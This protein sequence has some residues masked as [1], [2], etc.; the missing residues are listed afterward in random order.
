MSCPFFCS[1][2][3]CKLRQM[4]NVEAFWVMDE[5][6]GSMSVTTYEQYR[7]EWQRSH[8]MRVVFFV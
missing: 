1:R 6:P 8:Y 2:L 5:S 4:M 7:I 3:R